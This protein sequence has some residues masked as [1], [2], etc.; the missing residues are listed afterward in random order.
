M[1]RMRKELP[2]VGE[3]VVATVKQVFEY[4]AYL[5][6]DEYN[7]MEAYLPWSEVAS[8]WVR[9]IRDVIREGQKVVVKVIRVN[10]RNK[11]VDVSLKRV[12]DNE[13][14]RK[15]LEW[16]RAVRAEKILELA[17]K[18]IGKTLDEAYEKAGWKLEDYYG[19]IYAG[20]EQAVMRGPEGL[21]EAGIEEPW[22]SALYEEATRHIEV[23]KVKITGTLTLRSLS[24]DGVNRI[25][26]VLS[27]PLSKLSLDENTSIRVYTA[28]APRY[29][30]EVTSTDYKTAEKVLASY[31]RSAEKLS[32]K[33][34]VEF[35]F[36]RDRR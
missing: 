32:K 29:K 8:K 5:I 16:K 22:L 25:R 11:Q 14:R 20:L 36:E 26:R 35:G 10:R 34:S 28:G 12:F 4:G 19:E 30:I 13:R 24:P 17:A 15:M 18:K 6:L 23:K 27:E 1:V 21:K 7:S 9:N 3:L 33:L 31:I 2:D